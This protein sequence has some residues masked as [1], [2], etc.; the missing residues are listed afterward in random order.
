M[1]HLNDAEGAD[2]PWAKA[3][4]SR[5]IWRSMGFSQTMVPIGYDICQR[6]MGRELSTDEYSMGM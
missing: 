1:S 4:W 5:L 3:W 6:A 2:A